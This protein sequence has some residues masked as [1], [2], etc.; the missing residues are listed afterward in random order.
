MKVLGFTAV[1]FG[2]A[3]A[4]LLASPTKPLGSAGLYR[5]SSLGEPYLVYGNTSDHGAHFYFAPLTTVI[6]AAVVLSAVGIS[7][8]WS[9][10][11]LFRLLNL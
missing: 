9:S 2:C 7:L 8:L 3:L 4:G 1:A 11:R 10:R 6:G 5:E